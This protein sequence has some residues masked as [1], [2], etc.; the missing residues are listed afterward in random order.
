MGLLLLLW[1]LVEP[2]GGTKHDVSRQGVVAGVAV[3]R[4]RNAPYSVV[5]AVENVVGGEA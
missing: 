3:A 5:R 1:L 4:A 2:I